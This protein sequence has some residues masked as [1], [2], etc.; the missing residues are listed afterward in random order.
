MGVALFTDKYFKNDREGLFLFMPL[1]TSHEQIFNFNFLGLPV[2]T[3]DGMDY[4][5]NELMDLYGSNT[6]WI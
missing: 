1:R 5:S 4:G 6:I 2:A 3:L